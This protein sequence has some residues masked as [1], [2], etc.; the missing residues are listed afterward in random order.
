[1]LVLIPTKTFH[2]RF[3]G[4][5]KRLLGPSIPV[6]N[7]NGDFVSKD[8]GNLKLSPSFSGGMDIR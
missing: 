1:M 3:I 4:G 2:K 7:S 5:I 8:L 6:N